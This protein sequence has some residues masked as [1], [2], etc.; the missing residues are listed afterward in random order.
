MMND[1]IL[2]DQQAFLG[3]TLRGLLCKIGQQTQRVRKTM[4]CQEVTVAVVAQ[5]YRIPKDSS[6]L[7]H[8]CLIKHLNGALG[9]TDGKQPIP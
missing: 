3:L 8:A 9:Q 7:S 4:R 2:V 6:E 5:V 1:I